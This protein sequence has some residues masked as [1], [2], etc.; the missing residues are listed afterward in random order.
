MLLRACRY[1]AVVLFAAFVRRAVAAVYLVDVTAYLFLLVQRDIDQL[2]AA[3][4]GQ[5]SRDEWGNL[6]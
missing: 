3:G 2:R 5:P 1:G 6:G 4:G